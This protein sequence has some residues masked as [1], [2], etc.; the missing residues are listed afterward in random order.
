MLLS[1]TTFRRTATASAVA[2]ALSL[3]PV[4]A[5]VAQTL[6]LNGAGATFPEPLYQRYISEF[7]KK[8][9]DIQVNY[10]GIGSGGGIKQLTAETV[11]FAGSD[12]AMTDEEIEKVDRGVV[13]VPTAG[14]PVAIVYNLPGVP[15]NL[16]LSQEVLPDIFAG[17]ISRWNDPKIAA[18]NPGVD[19]PNRTIKLAVRADSSG[20]TFIFTNA[21]SAIDP[22]FKGRV[23]ANKAPRWPGRPI[24]SKGNPGVAQLV[25]KTPGTIGYVES[26]FA[27]TNQL[28]TAL[29]ENQQ[30]QFVAPTIKN[31]NLALA[32]VKFNQDF[33]IDFD[34][35]GDPAAGYPITG[36]TWI[37][38]YKQYPDA[39]KAQAIKKFVEYALT[40]GQDLNDDLVYT[41]IPEE[42]TTQVIETVNN[43]VS[44]GA[45]SGSSR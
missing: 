45:T 39:A 43:T 11:D 15:D 35:L 1:K 41:E 8:N 17:K 37:M 30:G 9:S 7:Q 10:Q 40:E 24:K 18:E 20:T 29:V 25:K 6:T 21:L 16:K 38:V 32:N 4:L 13:F 42:I 27:E 2:I 22:Y 44:A 36:L 26:S 5:A 3:G 34:K 14:G 33:R 31:A 28:Q 19:L 23:G 12:A